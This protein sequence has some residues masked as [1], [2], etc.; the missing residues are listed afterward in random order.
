L[1]HCH[2]FF[3]V[4]LCSGLF[5]SLLYIYVLFR[6]YLYIIIEIK[7]YSIHHGNVAT[8]AMVFSKVLLFFS[9]AVS[10]LKDLICNEIPI[11]MDS[12][13]EKTLEMITINMQDY[14]EHRIAFFKFL[15]EANQHCFYGLFRY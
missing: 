4:F 11:I 10:V 12:L 5:L 13:F 15:H 1:P 2:A 6:S 8:V 14:P 9:T 3:D 7:K